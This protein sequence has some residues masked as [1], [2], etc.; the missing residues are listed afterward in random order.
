MA[1]LHRMRPSEVYLTLYSRFLVQVCLKLATSTY[2]LAKEAFD[3]GSSWVVSDP[4][5]VWI[6]GFENLRCQCRHDRAIYRLVV[7]C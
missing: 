4:D 6:T 3:W 2:L 5:A 1:W 7:D